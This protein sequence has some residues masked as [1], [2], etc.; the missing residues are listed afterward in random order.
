M[1]AIHEKLRSLY[2]FHISLALDRSAHSKCS[3]ERLKQG[4]V[5]E[6]LEQTR[7]GTLFE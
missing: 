7:H 4:R 2:S 5:A 1:T 6:W 3:L